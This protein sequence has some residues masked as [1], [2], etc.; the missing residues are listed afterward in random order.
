MTQPDPTKSIPKSER[1]TDA[2]RGAAAEESPDDEAEDEPE[3]WTPE[4]VVEWNAYYDIYVV[5]G[6][7]LLAFIVSA[8][9][10]THSSIWTQ[11][12]AGRLIAEAGAPV[13]TDPF[14]YTR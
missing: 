8:N 3:P 11:L 5:L 6:V 2:K 13:T 12:Q 9:R 4:R 1:A 14:S 10:I 7:L